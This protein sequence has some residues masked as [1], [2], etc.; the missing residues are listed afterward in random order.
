[1]TI[2][3]VQRVPLLTGQA[4]ASVALSAAVLLLGAVIG[5]AVVARVPVAALRPSIG[6][7]GLAAGLFAVA[8]VELLP[9]ATYAFRA[10]SE[11]VRAAVAAALLL[12]EGLCLGVPYPAAVRLL[13]SAR[14]GLW[15]P[16]LWAVACLAAC[17]AAFL[18][19]AVGVAWSF[20]YSLGLGAVCL[21]AAFMIAGLRLLRVELSPDEAPLPTADDS[22]FRRPEPA[23]DP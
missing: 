6:W 9:L 14:R 8:L 22:L 16:A 15:A 20:A 21:L 12:P 4:P 23:T 7:A 3:I 2:P 13:A 10:Q 19:L 18:S 5:C 11:M 17:V 1:V